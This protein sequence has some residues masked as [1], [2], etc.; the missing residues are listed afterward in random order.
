[1]ENLDELTAEAALNLEVGE[2]VA[3]RSKRSADYRAYFADG[4]TI[5]AQLPS[6]LTLSVFHSEPHD[7]VTI[8][9]VQHMSS[10]GPQIVMES[11]S[12]KSA[13][14]EDVQV[15]LP[16]EAAIELAIGLLINTVATHQDL[17]IRRVNDNPAI[18]ALFNDHD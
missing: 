4:V 3:L 13:T 17:V 11:V 8:G 7:I 18:R 12:A 15:R 1:M 9:R 6:H 14:I 10:A 5:L 2:K 16:A